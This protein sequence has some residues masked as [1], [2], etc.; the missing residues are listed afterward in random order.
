MQIKEINDKQIWESFLLECQEKTFLS[1]WNWGEFQKSIED[2]IWRLGIYNNQEL[3]GV[4]L[5]I[6]VKARRGTFLF[7]PHSPVLKSL[8]HS[9]EL[10]SLEMLLARLREIA[11][12]EKASFIR[13]APIFKRTEEYRK[14]F[15]DLGFRKAPIHMHPEITWEIDISPSEQELLTGTRKTTRYLIKQAEKNPEIEI[16]K[17]NYIKDLERFSQL[18]KKTAQRHHFIPFSVDYLK[19]QFSCFDSDNQILIY[20]A[21]YKGEI[22]S[23]AIMVY[24]QGIGFYHHGASLSKYNSN[25]VPASYLLQWEAMKEAKSRNCTKYNFWGI[26]P[27]GKK[28]H[29]WSGLTLFKKGFGGY[30]KEY[31][32]TQDLPLSTS[33]YLTYLFERI[34]KIKRGL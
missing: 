21:K 3:I 34:R 17:S 29:P 4:C 20:L 26:A 23:G 14:A 19:N 18:L 15:K 6:K 11:K 24:W 1:S 16:F 8:P 33:Y 30:K 13:V 7:L 22:I 31:L 28:N 12:E 27:E 2:K 9:K 25:K 10:S 5:V 32:E